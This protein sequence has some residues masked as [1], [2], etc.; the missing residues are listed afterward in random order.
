MAIGKNFSPEETGYYIVLVP[1]KLLNFQP[2]PSKAIL[3]KGPYGSNVAFRGWVSTWRTKTFKALESSVSSAVKNL[4]C[5]SFARAVTRSKGRPVVFIAQDTVIAR[6][7]SYFQCLSQPSIAKDKAA[8]LYLF[9]DHSDIP[10]P[11]CGFMDQNRSLRKKES[12]KGVEYVVDPA[13]PIQQALTVLKHECSKIE[14][15]NITKSLW[16][17]EKELIPEGKPVLKESEIKQGLSSDKRLRCI[18][19]SSGKSTVIAGGYSTS[20]YPSVL[21]MNVWTSSEW[22]RAIQKENQKRGW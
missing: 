18:L 1:R 5:D 15:D 20:G 12:S 19:D 13:L 11:Y 21:I 14:K 3:V 8:K 16:E 17:I 9:C 2:V 4:L 22:K 7:L 10:A 6:V